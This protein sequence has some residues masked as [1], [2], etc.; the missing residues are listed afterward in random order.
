[1][2]NENIFAKWDN[3]IDTVGLA[4]DI[5]EVEEK[6]G[7][8]EFKEVPHGEYEVAIQQMELKASKKGDPMVSIWFKIVSD[9]EYKGSM[10]FFNQVILQAFQIHIVNDMLRKM[11]SESQNAAR[12]LQRIEDVKEEFTYQEYRNLIMDIFEEVAESFEYGLKYT[13]NTK[14][15]NFSNYEIKEVFVLE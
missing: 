13:A 3:T 11:V 15:S 2:S 9:G 10:I 1:M 6:G 12:Y 4:A 7:T 14:N 5:K 8:G